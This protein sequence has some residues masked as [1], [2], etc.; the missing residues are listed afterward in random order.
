MKIG[1]LGGT[2]GLGK[3][4]AIFLKKEGFD[5]TVTGRDTTVGSKI[6][7]ELKI[8]YSDDNK[9]IASLSD[10]V[11]VSVPID[12]I[13]DVIIEIS[14]HLKPGSLIL[15]VA[16]VKEKPFNIMKKYIPNNVEFIPTHPIFGPRTT[17]LEGQIIA[18][19]PENKGEWY[20]KLIK[21]LNDHKAMILEVSPKEH[22]KMMGIVQILT[23]FSYISTASTILKLGVD[24]KATRKF[25]SP[26]YNLMID[27]IGRITS[28][29][30]YLTYSIQRE[31]ECGEV[32]RDAFAKSVNEIKE[33]ISN[34]NK[35][36]F[37]DI[38]NKATKNIDNISSALGR[39]DKAI[40]PFTKK[41]S[42]FKDS[43]NKELA[44]KDIYS[45]KVHFGILDE[46]SPDFITLNP[47]NSSSNTRL[48]I[49]N[50]EVLSYSEL[51]EWKKNNLPSKVYN[52]GAIFSKNSKPNI[53]K[54][55]IK[56]MPDVIEVKIGKIYS[57]H[58]NDENMVNISFSIKTS[59]KKSLKKVKTLLEG[60]GAI[61][62]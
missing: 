15:D 33:A 18:L 22:D 20:E 55:T 57:D 28:Q 48:K 25:A 58:Q 42:H 39:S 10:I 40:D 23:H 62:N 11:I 36:K 29:N 59:D 30:P 13:C 54:D 60:F 56:K 51:I 38:V 9:E 5:V 32:V 37:F 3:T 31:N 1:V 16:S 45:N 17:T 50:I 6:S 61:V 53:I 44:V 46:I 24:I 19:T 34:N 35:E 4:I 2:K 21:F 47:S 14:T 49:A 41:I 43:I 26:I 7:K 27:I 52:I 12:S 8:K